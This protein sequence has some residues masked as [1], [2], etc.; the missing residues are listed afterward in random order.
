MLRRL[1]SLPPLA[2]LGLDLALGLLL[3]PAKVGEGRFIE[4]FLVFEELELVA[5]LSV[6]LSQGEG[7]SGQAVD[8]FDLVDHGTPNLRAST[9]GP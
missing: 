5:E 3:G 4:R 7:L 9:G 1:V 6:G 2:Q 8:F